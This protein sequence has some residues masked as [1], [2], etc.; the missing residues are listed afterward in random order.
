ME[1]RWFRLQGPTESTRESHTFIRVSKTVRTQVRVGHVTAVI[2]GGHSRA[3]VVLYE[4]ET[5]AEV[6]QEANEDDCRRHCLPGRQRR[7]DDS[8]GGQYS[9]RVSV[10]L[11]PL[12]YLHAYQINRMTTCLKNVENRNLTVV[13]EYHGVDRNSGKYLSGNC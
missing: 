2:A 10:A 9:V 3:R 5:P 13:R 8:Q 4:P 11:F 7:R 1:T 6:Y 12:F